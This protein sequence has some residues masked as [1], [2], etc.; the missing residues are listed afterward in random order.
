M[1]DRGMR[2]RATDWPSEIPSET[3]QNG[4]QGEPV[5]GLD[6]STLYLL[7]AEGQLPALPV[8]AASVAAPPART[9]LP[10]SRN[11]DGM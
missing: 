5:H 11:E 7:S 4:P 1:R 10:Q 9:G 3:A 2:A 6:L 8:M